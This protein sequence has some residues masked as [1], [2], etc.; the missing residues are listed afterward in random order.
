MECLIDRQSGGG[1]GVLVKQKKAKKI[2]G[3]AVVE[4]DG[5]SDS[6]E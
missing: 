3:N 6:T 1:G 2:R 5:V 4:E